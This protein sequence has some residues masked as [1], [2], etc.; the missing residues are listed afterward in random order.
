MIQGLLLH[1][2][3]YAGTWGQPT[4]PLDAFIDHAA[5]LGFDGVMLMAKRPHLSV[6]DY[7]DDACHR[8]R[9]RLARR[10]LRQVVIAGYNDLTAGF[11]RPDI[12]QVEYQIAHLVRLA[13]MARLLGGKVVRV[14]TGYESDAAPFERQWLT[15]RDALREVC[16]RVAE[17]GVT[18]GVQNHHDIAVE[19]R[20]FREL[21]E[22]VGRPN[23]AALFDA[24]APALHGEDPAEAAGRLGALTVHTTLAN[25]QRRDR[26]RYR[27]ALVNYEKLP[28]RMQAVPMQDGFIDYEAFFAALEGAG[29][30]GT[31][32]YE[33]C[34]PLRG[35]PALETLDRYAAGFLEFMRGLKPARTTS[36]GT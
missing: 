16:D 22:D 36:S 30:R 27:P 2:V 17:L 13:E 19:S 7:D 23:C 11:A 31:V 29:F 21:I 6:L 35:E 33:M 3:S 26:Y 12:P 4:L 8:L 34:S 14:F 15:I 32:A 10:G 24:W 25:Y 28:A 1:S 18:I 20:A 5:D 9:D